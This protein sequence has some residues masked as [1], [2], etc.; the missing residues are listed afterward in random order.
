MTQF[1]TSGDIPERAI[2]TAIVEKSLQQVRGHHQEFCVAEDPKRAYYVS[3]LTPPEGDNSDDSEDRSDNGAPVSEIRPDSIGVDFQP[4]ND[5]FPV[6][7]Q[8]EV[9]YQTHPTYVEYERL[10][11]DDPRD[12]DAAFGLDRDSGSESVRTAEEQQETIA[13][14]EDS[15]GLDV[16]FYRRVD[17]EVSGTL[18]GRSLKADAAD[19]TRE[20]QDELSRELREA[21]SK[22]PPTKEIL[23]PAEYELD[24]SDLTEG[25]FNSIIGDLTIDSADNLVWPLEFNVE[26]YGDELRF[27]LQLNSFGDRFEIPGEGEAPELLWGPERTEQEPSEE[28][29]FNPVIETTA[30]LQP[31]ELDLMPEDYRFEQEVWAKGH[32]CSTR[33]ERVDGADGASDSEEETGRFRIQ[34]TATPT[35]PVYE[36]EF[37]SQYDPDIDTRFLSLSGQAGDGTIRTLRDIA[38][39]MEAYQKEW[40]TTRKEEFAETHTSEEIKAFEEDAEIF[41]EIEIERFRDGI[42][43]LANDAEARRAFQLMN[44]VNHRVHSELPDDAGFDAWRLFQ[45]VFIVSNL[46][47]IVARDPDPAR[48]RFE[49]SYA[50][51]ADVLWFPTGGGK[52][53]AYVGIILFTLFFDRIRGKSR[54][55]SSWLRFPLR[56]LSSQQKSRFLKALLVAEQLRRQE[57]DPDNDMLGLDGKGDEFSLGF[58]V[59]SQDTPNKIGRDQCRLYQNSQDAFERDCQVVSKCPLCDSDVEVRFDEAR[60]L[61]EHYCTSDDCVGRLPLYVTDHDVYRY[62]PSILLGSLDKIAIMG[63]QPRFTNIFGNLTTECSVHGLGH[64][65][66]C[67]EKD[68]CTEDDSL[69]D[70]SPGTRANRDAT[71]FDPVPSLHLIDEVHLL[72]EELGTYAGHYETAYL[73]LCEMASEWQDSDTCEIDAGVRPKVLTSTATIA[74]YER[75]MW[76]LF[77]K[78]AV[79]FPQEG[80]ALR[81]TFYGKLH[82]TKVEREYAGVT[83]NNRTHLYAILDFIKRYHEIIRDY[84]DSDE[85]DIVR[86]AV[87]VYHEHRPDE[88]PGLDPADEDDLDTLVAQAEWVSD[89]DE[90][91]LVLD[92]YETSLT[93]FT[94][95]REKDQFRNNIGKQVADE[96]EAEGYN[97]DLE[98]R[99]LTADTQGTGVLDE[100][101]DPPGEFEQRPDTV[102][103]TSFVGHGIDNPRF[104]FLVF[105]G[106]PSQTF[107][108]IQASSRVGRES[109][110]PGF[111]VD[112]FRPF[113]LRDRHRYKY[114]ETLHQHLGRTV[115]P[116]A[117]DR[118]AKFG[119]EQTHPGIVKAIIRQYY[120]PK[121]YWHQT[122]GE[123]TKIET[124]SGEEKRVNAENARHFYQIMHGPEFPEVTRDQLF[125]LVT[126]LY[127]LENAD[128]PVD[129]IE[130]VLEEKTHR[131]WEI[132]TQQLNRE[133][134]TPEFPGNEGPMQN[135]R[136]IGEDG[137][138]SAF[139]S[140]EDFIDGLLGGG[141]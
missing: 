62:L 126:R 109:D 82:E 95:K 118:W 66:N 50:E 121:Y 88:V 113:D 55:V 74:K 7:I 47:D 56:L 24:L 90:K 3:N 106:Y 51:D 127:S 44:R 16:P 137:T 2:G 105:F 49:T 111:V 124:R 54:G 125:D 8:F 141:Y 19:L 140:T 43:M 91:H 92:K 4:V 35:A 52:T 37:R 79:R 14:P 69:S 134:S 23:D 76:N 80:P 72:N 78:D 73:E 114:F 99:Q 120:R 9:Y 57:N 11:S 87:R 26:R 36:F 122:N 30:T 132:W 128:R 135:L 29:V 83:P 12:V 17:I 42:E 94:N 41:D 21:A 34:S 115:E 75:Q 136:D 59:G 10:T 100:L 58:F 70:V 96:M 31:Y 68:I 61:P 93:Y 85:Q 133:M 139:D 81:E 60:N 32:N 64:S 63:F 39:G 46:P 71:Y 104:N 27:R 89:F 131:I 15:Y 86:D 130:E 48:D 101:L 40:I 123:Y 67:P 84:Y 138:V 5:E 6:R 45:L 116:V 18:H 77:H 103:C 38:D 107:Q 1:S 28:C 20:I 25:E 119:A 98:T 129:H 22:T 13:T 97:N 33:T 110:T 117:I 102:P 108:Y 53:E 65:G 112:F